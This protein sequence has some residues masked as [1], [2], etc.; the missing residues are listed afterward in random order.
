MDRLLSIGRHSHSKLGHNE[1]GDPCGLDATKN[2]HYV[3]LVVLP[4]LH[5]GLETH[6]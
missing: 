4:L 2:A 3:H 6:D 5:P 1:I